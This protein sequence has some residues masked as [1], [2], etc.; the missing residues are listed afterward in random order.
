M[1]AIDKSLPNEVRTNIKLPNPKEVQQEQQQQ[2]AGDTKSKF[3]NSVI[4]AE[5]PGR[6]VFL[7]E[8]AQSMGS[9][10]KLASIE[11]IEKLWF[12]NK[13]NVCKKG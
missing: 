7:D 6:D 12:K 13:K 11:E 3:Q 4:S 10:S 8:F 1:A 5:V 9:T 2:V